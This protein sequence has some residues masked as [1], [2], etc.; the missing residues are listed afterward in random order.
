MSGSVGFNCPF[1]NDSFTSSTLPPPF[2]FL[3]SVLGGF[4]FARNTQSSFS[5]TLRGLARKGRWRCF[6]THAVSPGSQLCPP[7]Q[8]SDRPRRVSELD[9][10]G[11]RAPRQLRHLRRLSLATERAEAAP[12][13]PGLLS[14]PPIC[15][16]QAALGRTT[17]PPTPPKPRGQ[18][19]EALLAPSCGARPPPLHALLAPVSAASAG[20]EGP[21]PQD[22]LTP[23]ERLPRRD[24]RRAGP[25]RPSLGRACARRW[26]SPNSRDISSGP[27]VTRITKVRYQCCA[28]AGKTRSPTGVTGGS[29]GRSDYQELPA[30]PPPRSR[31]VPCSRL[32]RS[33]LVPCRGKSRT[34]GRGQ[35]MVR[36][37]APAVLSGAPGVAKIHGR[38]LWCASGMRQTPSCPQCPSERAVRL[39]EGM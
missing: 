8:G 17:F 7:G 5:L 19:G 14:S 16:T 20:A 2:F 37:L 1:P 10:V 31:G 35:T 11:N 15:R 34:G 22:V 18:L 12:R 32:P 30:V 23:R 3:L 39:G 33:R 27:F 21:R 4:C 36:S 25:A 9:R 38:R 28:A 24:S 13:P 29:P 6:R 26:L